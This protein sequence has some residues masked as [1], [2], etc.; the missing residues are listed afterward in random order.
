LTDFVNTQLNPTLL[1]L[2]KMAQEYVASNK[3]ADL[4]KKSE[5]LIAKELKGVQYAEW[6]VLNMRK[7]QEK[8]ADFI[9]KEKTR[10]EGLVANKSTLPAK[11]ARESRL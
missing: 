10:L 11:Q 4:L 2:K 6:V 5:A 1:D 8:G 9:T 7:I 3:K